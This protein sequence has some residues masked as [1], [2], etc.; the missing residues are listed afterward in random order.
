[1]ILVIS[2]NSSLDKIYTAD[3][4]IYGGVIR[5]NTVNNTAGGKGIHV[6]DVITTLGE[7]CI[8]TGFLGG[9]TGKFIKDKLDERKIMHR[10]VTI[11]AETRS[12]INIIT[13]DGKQTEILELGPF[14]TIDEQQI[15]LERYCTLLEKAEIIVASGSLPMNIDKTFYAKLIYL[16]NDKGKKFLLD[17]SGRALQSSIVANPYIIKPNAAEMENAVHCEIKNVKDAVSALSLSSDQVE[18]PIIS[19][20]KDGAVIRYNERIYY[21]IPPKIVLSNAVGSGDAFMAGLA[22]G[23]ARKHDIK[24]VMRLACACGAAN[25]MESESGFVRRKNVKNLLEKVIIKEL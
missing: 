5:A 1:M 17:T 2:L 7:K 25:A 23:L 11:K 18:M 15:F 3:K 20:G 8:L 13:P 22:V 4:L 6:A 12:C 16:A 24:T 21:V 19:L 9:E 10:F 14:I